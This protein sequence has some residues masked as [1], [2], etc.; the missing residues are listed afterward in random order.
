[1]RSGIKTTV[2]TAAL[3]VLV[4]PSAHGLC[5]CL[6]CLTGEFRHFVVM[7]G[8]MKPALEP[9]DCLTLKLREDT[10]EVPLPGEIIGFVPEHIESVFIFRVVAL[11]GQTI[12]MKDG[13][14]ILDGHAVPQ[15][16]APDY[17]QLFDREPGGGMPR[18]PSL[19]SEGET[20]AIPRFT[21]TLPN[22]ASYDI[23]DIETEG[24]GDNTDVFTVP[25]G[26]V[27]VLGDNRDN[28]ADSRFSAQAGGKG[29]V[30]LDHI[31]GTF[32]QILSP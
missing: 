31:I 28:A 11:P 27:F 4:A 30:S 21:E 3:I 23:L 8:S 22:G 16:R 24:M 19:I 9:S 17:P 26:H 10:T 1:V 6:K 25:E 32:D 13:R 12:Q 14:L 2:F 18:C 15:T 7:S 5:L 20:C 29:F